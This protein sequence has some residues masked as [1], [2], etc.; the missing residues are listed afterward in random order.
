MARPDGYD[1]EGYIHFIK[2]RVDGTH[3]VGKGESAR[4]MPNKEAYEVPF[5]SIENLNL[6][7]IGNEISYLNSNVWN[8]ERYMAYFWKQIMDADSIF[9]WKHLWEYCNEEENID[10][11]YPKMSELM[12]RCGLSRPTLID[13][14]KKLEENNFLIQIHRLNK[15]SDNKKEDSP[16]FKL[17][18]TIPLL[19]KEQVEKLTPFMKK[20]HDDY[21]NKFA[22]ESSLEWFSASGKETVDNLIDTSGDR[23]VSSKARQEIKNLLKNEQEEGYIIANLPVHMQETLKDTD[24]LHEALMNNGCSKPSAEM[25]FK[26]VMSTYDSDTSTVHIVVRESSQKEYYEKNMDGAYKDILFSS[27]I[28]MYDS[29]GDIKYFTTEQYIITILKGK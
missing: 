11:C 8:V 4:E 2:K 9:V 28:E 12:Q 5:E 10:M 16:L 29:V 1:V 17:R 25:L 15:K 26:D 24:S 23:I 7:K 6:N 19:S 14:I 27:L 20:K 13:K 3:W 22:S 21:M 18:R